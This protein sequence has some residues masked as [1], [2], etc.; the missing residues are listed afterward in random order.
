MGGVHDKKIILNLFLMVKKLLQTIMKLFG[1]FLNVKVLQYH[2]YVI[3]MKWG[4][5]QME[6]VEP[7][8]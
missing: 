7:V 6:I 5:D 1:K 3:L 4:I 8:W 2:I